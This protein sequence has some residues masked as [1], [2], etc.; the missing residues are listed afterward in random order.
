MD[1]RLEEHESPRMGVEY[2]CSVVLTP[3]QASRIRVRATGDRVYLAIDRAANSLS[4]R[5]EP[6]VARGS[7]AGTPGASNRLP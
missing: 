2:R 7:L 5:L 3:G 6:Q 4:R 1:V